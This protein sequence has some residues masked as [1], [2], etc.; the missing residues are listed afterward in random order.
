MK[1]ARIE[2]WASQAEAWASNAF[3]LRCPILDATYTCRKYLCCTTSNL[4]KTIPYLFIK[5][6]TWTEDFMT[7]LYYR[8]IQNMYKTKIRFRVLDYLYKSNDKKHP[9]PFII[10]SWKQRAMAP[11]STTDGWTAMH[12][13][14]YRAWLYFFLFSKVNTWSTQVPD[15]WQYACTS[16]PWTFFALVLIRCV[17]V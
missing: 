6:K 11:C 14:L 13:S 4:A 3:W 10:C 1:E 12:S 8:A 7:K 5:Q 15:I 9:D 16:L 2:H 17:H